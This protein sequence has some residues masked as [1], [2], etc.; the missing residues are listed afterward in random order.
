MGVTPHRQ[1]EVG[2]V[3]KAQISNHFDKPCL[4]G[5]EYGYKVVGLQEK[6]KK[7][8]KIGVLLRG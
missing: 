6:K 2:V 8:K 3:T 4:S 5:R 7:K 1:R